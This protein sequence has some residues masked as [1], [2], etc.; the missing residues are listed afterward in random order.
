MSHKWNVMYHF[1][2]HTLHLLSDFNINSTSLKNCLLRT[3]TALQ[4]LR[5]IAA[6]VGYPSLLTKRLIHVYRSRGKHLL[7]WNQTFMILSGFSSWH[8]NEKCW[9]CVFQFT[10]EYEKYRWLF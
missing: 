2:A 10:G 7:H 3:A 1:K 4:N 9:S 5:E 6:M 8:S